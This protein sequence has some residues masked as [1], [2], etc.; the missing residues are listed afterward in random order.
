M[1]ANLP[2][3]HTQAK[4]FSRYVNPT[5]ENIIDIADALTML[6]DE[7]ETHNALFRTRSRQETFAL[8]VRAACWTLILRLVAAGDAGLLS[9]AEYFP[10]G[11]VGEMALTLM[12]MVLAGP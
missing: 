9:H 7:S 11:A 6:N 12:S 5:N 8:N 1:V 2:H 10:Q 3:G 4:T